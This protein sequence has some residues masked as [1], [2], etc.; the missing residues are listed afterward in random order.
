M[1]EVQELYPVVMNLFRQRLDVQVEATDTDLF[2]TG[3][4]DSLMFV[5]L[6]VQLE[7]A[8]GITIPIDKVEFENFRS[9]AAI[10]DFVLAQSLAQ[11]GKPPRVC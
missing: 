4:V 11:H 9:V 3:I 8:F 10:A 7:D 2:A 5:E 1:V 6:T